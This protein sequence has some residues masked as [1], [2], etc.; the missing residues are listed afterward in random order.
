MQFVQLPEPGYDRPIQVHAPAPGHET[1]PNTDQYSSGMLLALLAC[2]FQQRTFPH[3]WARRRDYDAV[4]ISMR[5]EGN[6]KRSSNL[7]A[8]MSLIV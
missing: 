7:S 8:L 3:T 1:Y 2:R 6:Y 4:W 5:D